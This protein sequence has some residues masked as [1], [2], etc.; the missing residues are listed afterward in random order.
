V[1]ANTED[2]SVTRSAAVHGG[3]DAHVSV[4]NLVVRFSSPRG[5]VLAVQDVSIDVIRAESVV[6]VGPSGCG[7]TTLLRCIGGFEKPTSG[8]V[9]VGD[10]QV[11]R[12][13]PSRAMVFQDHGLLPWLSTKKNIELGLRKKV[14][15]REER[16]RIVSKWIDRVGLTGFDSALPK[17]LS[18]G[19]QQRVAIARAL[20]LEPDVVLMDEPFGARDAQ[21]RTTMQE[22][23]AELIARAQ[24]TVVFITHD[25]D[26][27]LIIGDRILV[28]SGRPGRII[29]DLPNP[30][31]KPRSAKLFGDPRYA[32]AKA[33]IL[34]LLREGQTETK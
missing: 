32:T 2:P 11:T 28:M 23:T 3:S 33:H 5:E 16:A 22:V 15:D 34:S 6:I 13:S 30:F 12:P 24:M 29:E 4:R 8:T 19:M 17:Q 20:A 9:T 27:A 14:R 26:E 10:T 21:T 31:D 1:D 18:G 25:I 7:K